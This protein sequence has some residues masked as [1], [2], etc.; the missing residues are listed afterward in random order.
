MSVIMPLIFLN[1]RPAGSGQGFRLLYSYSIL[2]NF[3]ESISPPSAT[4]SAGSSL[5]KTIIASFLDSCDTMDFG[6]YYFRYFSLLFR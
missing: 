3:S 2:L 6:G 1:F 4:F 5:N